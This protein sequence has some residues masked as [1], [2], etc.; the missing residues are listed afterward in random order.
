VIKKRESI[1][2]KVKSKYWQKTQKYGIE[3]PKNI[4]QAKDL[5][6]NNENSLW[7]DSSYM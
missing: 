1:L 6:A 4:K 7:W 3:I 2:S 5:D